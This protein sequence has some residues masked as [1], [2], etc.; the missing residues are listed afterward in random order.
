VSRREEPVHAE[1]VGQ[2]ADHRRGERPQ[3]ERAHHQAHV[4]DAVPHRHH[5]QQDRRQPD[6]GAV[7]QRERREP[8]LEQP[9]VHRHHAES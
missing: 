7:D 6:G 2:A 8:R 1:A 4:T 9:P 3:V 5:R